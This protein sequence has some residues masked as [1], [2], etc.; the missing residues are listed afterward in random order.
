MEMFCTSSS[1]NLVAC[2]CL[3][4]V[5][6]ALFEALSFAAYLSLEIPFPIVLR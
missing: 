4:V 2:L 1:L 3:E 6:I 5:I